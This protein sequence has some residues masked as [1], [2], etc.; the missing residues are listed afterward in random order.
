MEQ[1]IPSRVQM[2]NSTYAFNGTDIN[3]SYSKTPRWKY[4]N[5]LRE[6]NQKRIKN[7]K[8][9][10]NCKDQC[11]IKTDPKESSRWNCPHCKREVR[12]L[13]SAHVGDGASD[14]IKK[15]LDE[16][17]HEKDIDILDKKVQEAHKDMIIVVCCDDCNSLLDDRKLN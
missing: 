6:L 2:I 12:R 16:Y 15:I 3:K 14:I 13:T 1:I 11:K 8:F 17:P 5:A 10:Q 9:I 7:Y 4:L